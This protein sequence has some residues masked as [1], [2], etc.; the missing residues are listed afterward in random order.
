MPMLAPANVCPRS[1]AE[2]KTHA[3]NKL[4]AAQHRQSIVTARL[5]PAELW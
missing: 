5:N 3:R 2:L 4:C 1:G